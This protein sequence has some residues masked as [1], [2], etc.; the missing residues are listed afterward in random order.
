MQRQLHR[1]LVDAKDTQWDATDTGS[2]LNKIQYSFMIK[3]HMV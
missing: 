1:I 2:I 3:K